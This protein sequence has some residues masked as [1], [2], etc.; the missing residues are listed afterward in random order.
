MNLV[1]SNGKVKITHNLL[2]SDKALFC[3]LIEQH[4]GKVIYGM[5]G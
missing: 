4:T 1:V 5:P 3:K 2:H